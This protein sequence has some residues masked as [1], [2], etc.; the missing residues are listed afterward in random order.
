MRH[1]GKQESDPDMG[2]GG[3]KK[4]GR[5]EG[6]RRRGREEWGKKGKEK[7]KICEMVRY[8]MQQ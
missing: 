4:E 8:E 1:A 3:E 6:G 2:A 7:T 5:K